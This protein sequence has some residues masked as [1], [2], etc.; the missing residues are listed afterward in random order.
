MPAR[1]ST[2]PSIAH[3]A[4]DAIPKIPFENKRRLD[5]Q[6]AAKHL[7]MPEVEFW[8]IRDEIQAMRNSYAQAALASKPSLP[9]VTDLTVQSIA[10]S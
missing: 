10:S 2:D 8:R 4:N 5:P 6:W 3:D 1:S 7:T 9:E